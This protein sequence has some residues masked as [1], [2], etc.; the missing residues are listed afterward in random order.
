VAVTEDQIREY[1]LPESPPK[2]TDRRGGWKVGTVQAEALAP[3]DLAVKVEAAIRGR[4]DMA[5]FEDLLAVE[6]VERREATR[7]LSAIRFGAAES[8]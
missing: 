3:D 5:V 1:G 7:V 4:I 6:R 8:S 2:K